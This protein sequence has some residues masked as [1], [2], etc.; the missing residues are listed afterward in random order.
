MIPTIRRPIVALAALLVGVLP[1]AC[2]GDGAGSDDGTITIFAPEGANGDLE[3]AWFTQHVE[4]TLD[5]ELSFE[6][7][8]YDGNAAREKRQISLA[9]GDLPDV[10]MLVPW[11]DQFS[12]TE[13]QRLGQQGVIVPLNDLIAE[14]APNI[15]AEFER[16]PEL[17]QLATAPDG[18]IYGLP[19]WND[20]YHCSYNAKLWMRS[21]W[22]DELGLDVPT[23]TEEMRDVLRAFKTED[24]NGNG[25]ADEIPLSGSTSDLVLPYFMNAFLYNPQASDVYSSTLALNDGSVQL[26]ASQEGWREGLRYL[27]SLFDEGLIDPGAFTD[28]RDALLAKGDNADAPIVG[29]ATVQHPG[30]VVTLNQEDGRDKDYDPVPPLTGP[31]GAQYAAYNLPS[32]AGATFVITSEASEETQVAAIELLDYMF[33]E[34]GHILAQF[35]QEG[36][37]WEPA[38]EGEVALDESLEPTFRYIPPD[39]DEPNEAGGWGPMAQYNDTE[40]FRNSQVADTDVYTADGFERRLFE[41]TKL[42]EGKEAE[43]QVYPYWNVWFDPD[44]SSELATLQTNIEDFVNQSSLQFITGDNDI[45]SDAEWESYLQNLD[46]LGLERYLELHQEAYEASLG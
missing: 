15:T 16:T 36:I 13:L 4:E 44:V 45:D 7:T 8:T 29:A 5:V 39:P 43:D 11:V 3:D 26:Q 25:K 33:S 12:K 22:L 35:G 34:E 2:S 38:A 10:Y 18:S 41:A 28:N 14:H 9:S 37:G 46:G 19:Q 1:A 6:T 30:L 20:C 32:I 40:E 24:P 23:T 31:D 17:E 21:D 42:Y 27:A